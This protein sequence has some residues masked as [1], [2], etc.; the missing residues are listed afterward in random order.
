MIKL[1]T[2]I[3]HLFNDN[4]SDEQ[5][6]QKIIDFSDQLEARERTCKLRLPKTTHYHIDF[7][8]N[9][10]L[11]DDHILF[12]E[13][14]VKPREEI[15]TLTFQASKD[16]EKVKISDGRYI[17][18][19]R[20][21]PLDEQITNTIDSI[22]KIKDI[23]GN[24]RNIGIENNNYYSTGAYDICTSKDLLSCA[25]HGRTLHTNGVSMSSTM[26]G[27]RHV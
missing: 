19:S 21:I 1:L 26:P 6:I 27:P 20:I 25:V 18:A 9:L 2:P 8:L 14:E 10:G 17:P 15:K 13:R 24:E 3:S 23:V 4:H 16:C 5:I 7:D 22:K 11:T 12:L